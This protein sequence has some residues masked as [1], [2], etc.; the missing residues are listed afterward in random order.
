MMANRIAIF[1]MMVCLAAC[2][3]AP[4]YHRPEMGVP[5]NYKEA[6]G[7]WLPA[8]PE[9]ADAKRGPWWQVYNDP[10]LNA[11]EEKVSAAN[12]DLKAAVARYQEARAA[13]AVARAGFFPTITATADP[14]R[15]HTSHNVASPRPVSQYNDYV[16]GADV[17]YELD[18]WGRVHN[19]AAA[20]RSRA[21]ASAAD[22]A[23]M[24]LSLHAELAMDYFALRGEDTTQR[25]ADETVVAYQKALELTRARHEGGAA[26]ETDVDQAE[27]Q[28]ENT[29][30]LAADTKLKR[31]QLEHAIAVLTGETPANFSLPAKEADVALSP[32]IP[33]LPS[34]LL[35]Q[36]PDIAAAALRVKA[37]NADIGVA[38]AAYFPDFSLNA[39]VGYESAAASK[40]L[41]APSLF[42]SFGPA[43]TLPFFDG[44]KIS[45]LSDEAHAVYDESVANYRQTVLTAFQEVEDNLA[46]MRQLAEESETQRAAVAAAERALTQAKNRY[47]GGIATYLDVVVA[48]NTALQAELSET[49]IRTRHFTTSVLLVKA[50]GG[51]W[52]SPTAHTAH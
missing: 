24:D 4:D 40:L 49:D 45:A 51:G 44:G 22:L 31:A 25:I 15:Q 20:G 11:L 13:A 9:N 17:S 27:T 21:K 48:Q 46:A 28:L 12:Q 10:D 14:T 37:A 33:Q 23:A 26:A 38:R 43:A 52:N 39:A 16:G 19:M 36:R 47:R 8:K 18:V 2:S 42:W 35:E 5:K 32:I 3:L 41:N 34:A 7:G 29:K 30:T 6:E 1:G 50:L